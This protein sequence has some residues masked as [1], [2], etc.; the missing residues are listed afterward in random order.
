MN[1]TQ[2]TAIGAAGINLLVA[3]INATGTFNITAEM[4]ANL[5]GFLLPMM[6]LFL[7]DKVDRVDSKTTEVAGQ[8]ADVKHS[9][10]QIKNATGA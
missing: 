6:I 9:T 7:G 3:I 1:R 10:N 8:V 2:L 5:N 4:V